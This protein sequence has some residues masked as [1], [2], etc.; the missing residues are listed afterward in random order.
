VDT[1]VLLVYYVILPMMQSQ[2]NVLLQYQIRHLQN[3]TRLKT[4]L[5]PLLESPRLCRPPSG[6]PFHTGMRLPMV[7]ASLLHCILSDWGIGS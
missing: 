7:V 2:K 5:V 3:G 6:S 1:W 4:Y